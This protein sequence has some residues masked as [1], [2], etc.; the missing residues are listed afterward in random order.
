[1]SAVD[2]RLARLI[3]WLVPIAIV[4]VGCVLRVLPHCVVL[5]LVTFMFAWVS[6]SLPIGVLVGNFILNEGKYR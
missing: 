1:M 6:L 5:D 3:L 2:E 4:I